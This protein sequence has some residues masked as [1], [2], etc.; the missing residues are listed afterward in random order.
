LAPRGHLR[1]SDEDRER[2]AERLRRAA[3]EGRILP[4][5]LDE[6]LGVAFSAR[7]YG[8]LDALVAD[9]PGDRVERRRRGSIAPW[10]GPAVALTIAIPL[11]LALIAVLLVVVTGIMAGWALW[12]ALGW[13]FFGRHGHRYGRHRAAARPGL[14]P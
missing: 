9:L 14:R 11:A 7:T 4:E 3:T 6:R 1:A 12:I 13:W 10:V 8:Q 2:I 5:E